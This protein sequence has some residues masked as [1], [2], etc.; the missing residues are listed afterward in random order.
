MN[1]KPR[2][3]I[4]ITALLLAAILVILATNKVAGDEFVEPESLVND[5]YS[6]LV[7]EE[8]FGGVLDRAVLIQGY[9][10]KDKKQYV[11]VFPGS[12]T[13]GASLLSRHY[14][15][16]GRDGLVKFMNTQLIVP[17]DASLVI[18]EKQ[19]KTLIEYAVPTMQLDKSYMLRSGSQIYNFRPGV[20]TPNLEEGLAIMGIEDTY[21]D[22]ARLRFLYTKALVGGLADQA[23]SNELEAVSLC[24][25]EFKALG[26]EKLSVSQMVKALM[27][28]SPRDLQILP[29]L[30][31]GEIFAQKLGQFLAVEGLIAWDSPLDLDF[32]MPVKVLNGCGWSGL[33]AKTSGYLE[34]A[35]F[36]TLEPASAQSFLYKT[37]EIHYPSTPQGRETAMVLGALLHCRELIPQSESSAKQVTLILGADFNDQ[38]YVNHAASTSAADDQN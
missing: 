30:N 36:Q 22:L 26:S 32:S 37:S 16:G 23:R 10:N 21:G 1:P 12:Y 7:C 2:L 14:E 34:R 11:T 17:I 35:G 5:F 24:K 3:I 18:S 27:Q 38:Y 29:A 20:Y 28:R 25:R 31:T 19:R 4:V 33:A 9:S 6:V 8:G 13:W 15:K